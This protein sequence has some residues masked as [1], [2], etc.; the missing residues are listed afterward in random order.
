M[1]ATDLT[2]IY[3]TD[4]DRRIPVVTALEGIYAGNVVEEIVRLV[5]PVVCA[6]SIITDIAHYL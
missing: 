3:V 2:V 1:Q 6:N 4:E 5:G